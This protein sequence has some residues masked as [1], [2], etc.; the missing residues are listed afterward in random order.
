MKIFLSPLAI[1]KFELLFKYLEDEWG[2]KAKNLFINKLIAKFKQIST[3]PQS[4]IQSKEFPSLYKCV[5]NKHSSLFYRI[6]GGEI[7][8][9]TV[10][11]NRQDPKNISEE[12]NKYFA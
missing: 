5:I 4:C 2:I 9:V 6:K 11:D 7:E 1:K 10:I 12:L 3:Y 8:I